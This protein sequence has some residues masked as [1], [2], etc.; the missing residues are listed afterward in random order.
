M[1]AA[2]MRGIAM[3]TSDNTLRKRLRRET[4]VAH[5]RLDAALSR[6][7]LADPDDLGRFLL[8]QWR[9]LAALESVATEKSTADLLRDLRRRAEADLETL[10]VT[11]PGPLP[12]LTFDPHDLAVEY[13]V[14]GSRLGS[15]VLKKRWLASTDDRVRA[16]SAYF[17]GADHIDR[18]RAFCHRADAASAEGAEADA[19]TRDAVALFE[20]Y[21][22]SARMVLEGE[23]K[24]LSD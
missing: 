19:I 12:P 6:L 11:R 10:G 5:E 2:G 20:F 21:D 13:L 18:W 9:P 24:A 3:G 23:G 15:V 22:R 14:A 17:T 4:H 16:A 8:S 1:I 7:D